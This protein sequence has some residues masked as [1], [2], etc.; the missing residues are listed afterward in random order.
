[1]G[2]NTMR[3]ALSMEAATLVNQFGLQGNGFDFL[4]NGSG[5]PDNWTSAATAVQLLVALTRRTTFPFHFDSL[6][7]LGVMV[8]LRK[9]ELTAQ[10][11]RR[12]MASLCEMSDNSQ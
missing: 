6:P 5:S 11:A 12:G 3:D 8:L 2:V 10:P 1:M 4:T 7:M 9:L